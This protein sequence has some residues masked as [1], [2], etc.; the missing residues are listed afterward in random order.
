MFK[1]MLA[2]LL[3]ILLGFTTIPAFAA[4]DGSGGGGNNENYYRA[5]TELVSSN[6]DDSFFDSATMSIGSD[7]LNVDGNPV[8]LNN[9][10]EVVS[11][12]LMLPS[13]VF[14]TLGAKVLSDSRGVNVKKKGANIEIVYG[15]KSIKINGNKKGIPAA[16]ALKNGNPVLPASILG[17]DGLGFEIVFNEASGKITIT[18]E[19]QMA[20]LTAKVRPGMAAPGNIGA[21]KTIAGPDGLYVYQFETAGQAKTA[22]EILNASQAV[23]F[24]EP[25]ILVTVDE[26]SDYDFDYESEDIAISAAYSHLG[27]GPG[28]IGSDIY[29]DYLIGAGKQNN[30]VTVAVLDTGLDT[31]H[32]YFSGRYIQGR[33]FIDTSTPTVTPDVHS[34]GTH[35]AGTVVDVTIALPNVKIMPVKVLGD[36][37]RGSSTQVSN[38]IRWAA[39]NGAKVINMSLGGGHSQTEDDSVMYAVGKNVTVVVAAGNDG[40]DAKNHCPAHIDA[41]ITVASFDSSNRPASSSNYGPCVD[42]AA[43]GVSIVSTIP[44]GGTGSKSGTSMAS[45]HVAGAAALLLCDNPTLSPAS[46]KSMLRQYVDPITTGGNN[47]Y[48]SGILNIGKAAG[49]SAP[50]FILVNPGGIVENIYSGS[51]QKQL[52]VEYYNNGTATN[53]TS[54]STFSSSNTNVATVTNS[55]LVTVIAAGQANIAVGYSG[56][57]ATVP[58]I[59]ESV[60]PLTVLSSTPSNGSTNVSVNTTISVAFNYRLTDAVSFT[61]RDSGG[62]SIGWLSQT[63]GTTA[64]I[65]LDSALKPQTEYTFTIPVGGAKYGYGALEQAYTMKFSTGGEGAPILVTSVSLPSTA[66]ISAGGTTTLTATVLPSNATNKGLEWSS[67][68]ASVATVSPTGLVTGVAGGTAVITARATD[69]SGRS[70]SCT[71]TVTV[72]PTGVTVSPSEATV[73]VGATHQLIATLTPSNATG[74]ITWTSGNTT[75]A[76]VSTSGLVTA[77]A[78]GTAVITAQTTNGLKATCSIT[79]PDTIPPVITL[80]GGSTITINKGSAFIEPG[81]RAIDNVDGDISSKVVVTGSVNTGVIGTYILTYTVSDIAGNTSSVTRT[82]HVV[83]N[84]ANFSFSDK[85]KSGSSFDHNFTASFPG[86]ATITPTGVDSKTQITVTIKNSAGTPVFTGAFST[87]ATKTVN[88]A[89]GNYTATIRIDNTNGNSTVGVNISLEEAA[90]A[91]PELSAPTVK[92][93]GSAQI[94]LHLGGSPYIEQGVTASDKTDGDI[95]SQAVVTSNVDTS[96]AGNYTVKYTVTNS[97][98]LSASVTRQ[99]EVVA[100]QTRNL[101]GNS[102]SFAPKDKQG[103]SFSYS[104]AVA[105]GGNASLNVTVPNN[106]KTTITVTDPAGQTVFTETFTTGGTRSFPVSPGNHTVKV[107]IDAANGNTTINVGLTTPGGTETYFPK[108]EVTM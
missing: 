47:Y 1:K 43:P 49:V 7:L 84:K 9:K 105:I 87:A 10:A 70:G 90:A 21:A 85:G 19:Y 93:I 92:L 65:T 53:V 77:R 95:S 75:V 35:V 97:A 103:A 18:N 27:W 23:I 20:R 33:N 3:T 66:S 55:G 38:G 36:D 61:L 11:G 69:G 34:H 59:G 12:E 52:S 15:E 56:L 54:Q 88:L 106:T 99:V 91:P 46:V 37:G 80:T 25:D 74:A 81:Y 45:P 72:Q 28:R 108:P 50:R 102:Y 76:T 71:V 24:A 31:A 96:K 32:P 6:W 86:V 73:N 40:D 17:D 39:D 16:A 78:A 60:G 42:V 100:S 79:V 107:S 30:A 98:G 26:D 8:R 64:V 67:G 51:R 82:V 58:V 68:N 13:E 29:L 44:G 4:N 22:C 5:M 89:A 62:A 83:G 94:V 63:V 14:E 101:P 41:A 48:G 104:A 2:L 57:S